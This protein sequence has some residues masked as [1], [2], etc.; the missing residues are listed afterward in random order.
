MKKDYMISAFA[1]GGKLRVV[2]TQTT[3]LT[4]EGCRRHQTLPTAS[5][6]LGRTLTG[7]ICK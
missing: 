6:A 7:G 3:A 4:Q 5:A 2:A 1:Y